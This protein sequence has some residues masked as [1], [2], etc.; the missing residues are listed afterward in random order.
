MSIEQSKLDV[1][2]TI[3]GTK[4]AIKKPPKLAIHCF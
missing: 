4:A 3:L 1:N 2:E